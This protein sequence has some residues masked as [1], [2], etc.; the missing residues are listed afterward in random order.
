MRDQLAIR[1]LYAV[2]NLASD[3]ADSERYADC[4][5]HEGAMLCPEVGIDVR[6]RDALIAH[7]D[8]DRANRAGQYRRHWNANLHLEACE[9][10]SVRGRCYLIAY[11]G[12]PGA[13][14]RVADCGVYV[15]RVIK[16]GEGVWRFAERRLTMDGSTWGSGPGE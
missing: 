10:G 12:E 1:E 16:D 6:G 13:L 15:D 14:P 8:R 7:K 3:D 11:Q 4:F 2:Y 9:D 5:T